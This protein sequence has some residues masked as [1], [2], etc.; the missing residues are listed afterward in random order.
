[1]PIEEPRSE[2]TEVVVAPAPEPETSDS[3]LMETVTAPAKVMRIGSMV[4][5]LLEEVRAGSYYRKF[6]RARSFQRL[7]SFHLPVLYFYLRTS[8]T[9]D[10]AP[11]RFLAQMGSA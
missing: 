9:L 5:Q 3:E 11:R 2:T 4:K 6:C 7:L 10:L 1:M 8:C